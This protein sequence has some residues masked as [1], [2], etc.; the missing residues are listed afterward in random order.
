MSTL[1][2]AG[3]A[4][5][6]RH[7]TIRAG[8]VV[9]VCEDDLW[10]ASAE[11]GE[12]YR[13]TAAV[14]EA[15]HPR[16]SPDGAS[17]AFVGTHDGAPEVYVLP[18]GGGP[19]ERLTFQAAR[20]AVL[21]WDER[22][23]EVLY[24]SAAEAPPG[25]GFRL[26][27][28][29]PRGGRPR[30]LPY[31]PATAIAPGPG[32]T[33]VL[34]RN[35]ADPARWKRY[36]GGTAGE[37][38]LGSDRSDGVFRRL[39]TPPGNV[40]APCWVGERLYFLCDHEGVGNVYSM[41]ADGS[42]LTR[43]SEH[44]DFYARGLA[45]DGE[46]LVYHVGA[47]LHLLD[48]RGPAGPTRIEVAVRS[49]RT[50][51]DQRLVPA[52][53]YLESATLSPDGASLAVA[54][55]GRV[56][57]LAHWEGAVR[58][59]GEPDGVR[60]RHPAWLADGERIVAAAADERPDER[61]VV[62]D[63][64]SSG[65]AE[66]RL[67]CLGRILELAPA[68]VGGLVAATTNRH[69]LHLVDLEP[70]DGEPTARRVDHS[71]HGPIEDPAWSADGAW[72]AYA[73]P[74]GPHVS[75]IRVVDTRTGTVHRITEPVLRDYAPCFDPAGRYLYFLGQRGLAAAGDTVT[76]G[77]GLSPA[78]RPY[79]VALR[80]DVPSPFVAVPR[81]P[82]AE[83][84]GPVAEDEDEAA[85]DAAPVEIDF[86]AIAD[87]VAA[88]PVPERHYR[89]V[90]ALFDKVLLLSRPADA[91]GAAS[92]V[93][94]VFDF[95]A[96]AAT[97]YVS[98]VEDAC[99]GADLATLLCTGAGTLRVVRARCKPGEE[100]AEEGEEPG[101]ATGWID[102][103]R[104]RLAVRP[105]AEW[106]QMFRE[107]WRLQRD[108]F[109][110]PGMAG[111]PWE[112]A[113]ERYRPLL[114]LV[115]TRAE[116]SDLLWE[117][118]GELGTS[119][120]YEFGGEYR[121]RPEHGQGF[122]GAEFDQAPPR[123]A[124]PGGEAVPGA[125]VARI[126]RGDSWDARAASP[127]AR[128]G[129]DIRAG[130]LVTA[131]NGRPVGPAGPGEL[132]AGQ[133]GREVELTVVRSGEVRRVCVQAL[134]DEAP[135]RYRDWVRANRDHVH[136]VSGGR[137]GYLHVPDMF[138]SGYTA[139]ARGF[140]AEHERE[141]LI[142]DVRFNGGGYVSWLLLE[143]LARRRQGYEHGRWSGVLPYPA[144]AARGPMVAL[145]N[146]HT[147]SDGDIFS[148]LFRRLGLGP[149]LG[150]RTWGGVIAVEPRYPLVDGTMTTQPEYSYVF[151]DVGRGL[152]NS[153]VEPDVEVDI[154]PHEHA[155]GLD[156]QLIRA[157]EVA[158]DRI[159]AVRETARPLPALPAL[160]ARTARMTG[161]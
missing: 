157:A 120:A 107:A 46:R 135:L 80:A 48:P 29:D 92:G 36:R 32:G 74:A 98:G 83:A 161:V 159:G 145:V 82:A 153:G 39:P 37:L 155:L 7:P 88:F 148:H 122:L 55:R 105:R 119:H 112:E 123:P 33:L 78:T 4:G 130:D 3:R 115:A 147:G 17:V 68:P 22:T 108:Q 23:G 103:D 61:L 124:E 116:L 151:D 138:E 126:L 44:R 76:L 56:Y 12:A 158:L 9:F 57:A 89:R 42:G 111:V 142:V 21:G 94:E 93:I 139:F 8:Q 65:A 20:C 125:R 19:A 96:Q 24:A 18:L 91:A 69:E 6:L 81:S 101:R 52:A 156:T 15:S 60:Y 63:A 97:E 127:C 137:V 40:A 49:A 54:A 146:E 134:A 14:A 79:V 73:W 100:A 86:D 110:D 144:E 150:R 85:E 87:R 152:E 113:Y 95:A 26:F 43:H 143:R 66:P 141:A 58:Q 129:A 121:A 84:P 67:P 16:L 136:D 77:F 1:F 72:L 70:A 2:P 106:A 53:E 25:F 11:G 10:L 131:V 50:Q 149:L 140:L 99:L 75:E 51:L 160:S 132:L 45:T 154:A 5:Y 27:A 62:L 117:L 59:L 35:T 90:L 128:I 30:P 38:W 64:G 109:W 102:L 71:P 47:R 34:G 41:L 28:V 133:G 104:L 118:Q 31:G 13:I 114:D